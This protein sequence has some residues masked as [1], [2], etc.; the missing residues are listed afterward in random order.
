MEC[1]KQ[2]SDDSPTTPLE[3]I[4]VSLLKLQETIKGNHI[5]MFRALCTSFTVSKL[6][7]SVGIAS[8]ESR[9]PLSV[10]Y[11]GT[12]K[13]PLT[14]REGGVDTSVLFI[15]ISDQEYLAAVL[16]DQIH[17]WNLERNTS[18][19][20]YKFQ[21]S[22]RWYLCVIDERTVACA[23]EQS[24]SDGFIRVFI[25]NTDSEKF[26]LSGTLH[27]KPDGAIRDTC[28]IKTADGT[29]CFL[30]SFPFRSLIRCVEMVGGRVRW[31]VG[32]QQ[33]DESFHPW[34]ICKDGSTVFVSDPVPSM[35][36]LLS[37]EDGS[38]LT[39]INLYPLG[40]RLPSCVR[41]QGDILYV[42]HMNKEYI[43]CISK[44]TKPTDV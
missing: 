10:V 38:V 11:P 21:E 4:D 2:Q 25:L 41:L 43:Y 30:L 18:S 9:D 26:S 20:A 40:F 15:T 13:P 3:T 33:M 12:N 23:A 16:E 32:L 6:S 29:P 17:I 39:S 1:L 5:A 31:Q 36:H 7:R 22:G 27:V 42:G 35:L 14:L 24:S 37:V 8:E 19:V 44:F 34:S 28:H